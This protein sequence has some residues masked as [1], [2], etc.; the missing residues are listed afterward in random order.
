MDVSVHRI[1]FLHF[2]AG[3]HQKLF[4]AKALSRLRKGIFCIINVLSKK[5]EAENN[6]MPSKEVVVA[7]PN[8]CSPKL[9]AG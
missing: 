6:G 8:I 5:M 4:A 2:D 3:K 1:K 7:R 9:P